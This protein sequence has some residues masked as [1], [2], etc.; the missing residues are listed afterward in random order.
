MSPTTIERTLGVHV[1]CPILF[2]IL[3]KSVSSRQILKEV[4]KIKFHVNTPSGVCVNTCGLTD[5]HDAGNWRFSRLCEC[6]LKLFCVQSVY[7]MIRVERSILWEMTVSVNVRKK[8]FILT[9][10]LILNDYRDTAA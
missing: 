5:G 1:R 10:A 3:T 6:A 7:R 8:K 2:T 9:C 4:A